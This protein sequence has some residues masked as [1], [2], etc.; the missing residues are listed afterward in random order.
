MTT[1]ERKLLTVLCAILL[2]GGGTLVFYLMI[3]APLKAYND[4]LDGLNAEITERQTDV[5]NILKDKPKVARW[6]HFGLPPDA[7][8]AS[9]QYHSYLR[10]L[11]GSSGLSSISVSPLQEGKAASGPGK[12]QPSHTPISFL[13]KANGELTS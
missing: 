10:D 7:S 8:V 1:R 5:I 2:V 12:K 4:K 3:L 9:S 13:I 6:R 11:L